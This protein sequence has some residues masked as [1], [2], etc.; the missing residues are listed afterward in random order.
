MKNEKEIRV[1]GIF[2]EV[3]SEPENE[4]LIDLNVKMEE[5]YVKVDNHQRTNIEGL[6]AAGD[7]TTGSAKFQQII[8][9]ASEGAISAHTAYEER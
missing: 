2:V 5:G 6:Y 9:A 7:C 3:G 1:N 4:M 8:T